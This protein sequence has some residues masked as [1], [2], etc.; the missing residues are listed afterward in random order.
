MCINT[1]IQ[2]RVPKYIIEFI[3]YFI[4]IKKYQK[5]KKMKSLDIII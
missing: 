4:E 2:K 3:I 5:S 1:Y